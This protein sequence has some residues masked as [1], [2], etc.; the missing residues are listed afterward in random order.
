MLVIVGVV[1]F[2]VLYMALLYRPKKGRF[3]V[4]H[5]SSKQF[6]FATS[7]GEYTIDA[8]RSCVTV[9]TRKGNTSI[10][11]SKISRLN[12]GLTKSA[13]L[14]EEV[15]ND[16]DIWDMFN[17]YEDKNYWFAIDAVLSNGK[18]FPLY[19]VGQY[20][21]REPL[22]EWWFTLQRGIL[23]SMGLFKPVDRISR[24]VLKQI[25]TAFSDAGKQLTLM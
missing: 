19:V 18:K 16:F 17:T 24:D 14:V 20:E 4:L 3:K 7:L 25:Q 11:F 22:S 9:H 15:L 6:R 2:D 23:A 10:P 1:I 8:F 21:P 13:A 12:Y 5:R